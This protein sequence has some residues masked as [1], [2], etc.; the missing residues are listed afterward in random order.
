[1]ANAMPSAEDGAKTKLFAH[2][3]KDLV[4]KYFK[5]GEQC[6]VQLFA[7]CSYTE[8]RVCLLTFSP[9]EVVLK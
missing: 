5:S 3:F 7:L 9:F 2:E 8:D 1:M 4:Q 6:N